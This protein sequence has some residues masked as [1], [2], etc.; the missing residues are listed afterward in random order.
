MAT[1]VNL[2]FNQEQLGGL[3]EAIRSSPDKGKTVW[4]AQTSWQG[5]FKSRATIPRQEGGHTVPMD[6]PAAL[7][8]SDSA[9]NMVEMVLGAYGCCLTTGFV[10]N[11]GM[12]GIKLEGVDIELEG[13]LG[14]QGF[15]GL[16]DPEQ[17]WPGY[18]EV[19]ARVNLKAS[20]ATP[21]QLREL[22]EK[23]VRTSPVGCIISRPVAVKTEMASVTP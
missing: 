4:K 12:Q 15:F 3:I 16:K 9:P 19:R 17:V 21:E 11:A 10:A 22:Y 8:G 14:L 5:G 1:T 18:T 7:G 20:E 13:D 6:E 2:G 23:V